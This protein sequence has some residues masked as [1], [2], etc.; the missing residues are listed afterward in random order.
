VLCTVG[1]AQKA[2]R[3]RELGAEVAIDYHTEDFTEAGPYNVILDIIGAKYLERNVR[4]LA[5]GGRLVVIGLQGGTKSELDLGALLAKRATVYATTLRAR[6]LEEKATIVASV[7][8]NVW[9]LIESGSV[10][11]IIDETL[12][13][14]EA[15]QAHRILER[16]G[17][18][19]KILL[20]TERT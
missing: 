2:A 18:I 3:C 17:H 6:P 4:S 20:E 5:T 16:S 10:R 1:N 15:A 9:P 8:K 12:P 13:M 7:R 14:A 11:P 19:G